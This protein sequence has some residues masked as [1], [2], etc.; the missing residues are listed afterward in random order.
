MRAWQVEDFDSHGN[1]R[2]R[3]GMWWALFLLA[4]PWWLLAFEM[5]VEQGEGRILSALYLTTE[6]LTAGLV[7]SVSVFIFLFIYPFRHDVRFLM[8]TV[9]T[10]VLMSC[11]GMMVRACIQMYHTV[12]MHDELLWLSMCFLTLGCLIEVWPDKRNREIFYS[13]ITTEWRMAG[14]RD[15]EHS[16]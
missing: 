3:R 11:A 15:A 7:C 14:G 16:E 12:G 6:M 5:S 4:H 9:Y 2:V 13:G 8:A 1:L 10:L